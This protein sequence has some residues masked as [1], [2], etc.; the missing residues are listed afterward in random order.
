VIWEGDTPV[1]VFSGLGYY[2]GIA[3]GINDDGWVT[4]RYQSAS[5]TYYHGFMLSIETC[6]DTDGDGYCHDE[7]ECP[8]GSTTS[9]PGCELDDCDETNVNVNPGEAEIPYDGLDNDCGGIDVTDA[10][11]DGYDAEVVGGE[12][13]DD[14]DASINPG[15]SDAFYD[16]IDSNCDGA[17]EWDADGDGYQ[18]EAYN[19]DRTAGGGDCDDS[20]A[21]INP[22]AYDDPTNSID[23]DCSGAA[24]YDADGDGYSM[25]SAGGT[26][27]DDSNSSIYP[28]APDTWYDGI[29]SDCAGDDDYDQDGDGYQHESSP[30]SV[31]DDCDDTDA[32]VVP[33]GTETMDDGVDSDCDGFE[34]C[35]EDADDDGYHDGV[36]IE[37]TDLTCT[38][39]GVAK[40]TD[41]DGDCDDSDAAKPDPD[42][43]PPTGY[44]IIIEGGADYTGASP[45]TIEF[46][47]DDPS[48]T[49]MCFSE[50]YADCTDPSDWY[51][52]TDT[53]YRT[54]AA[55]GGLYTYFVTFRNA[56]DQQET[57]RIS[58]SIYV[59]YAA[60]G[61]GDLTVGQGDGELPVS[62]TEASDSGS[63]VD[64]YI[65]AF[66]RYGGEAPAYFCNLSGASDELYDDNLDSTVTD[67]TVPDLEVG[68]PIYFRLCAVDAMG[69]TSSGIAAWGYAAPEYNAPEGSITIVEDYS[70]SEYVDVTP[71]CTDDSSCEP[72]M[73][74]YNSGEY[75]GLFEDAFTSGT[76]IVHDLNTAGVSST[77]TVYGQF[78][79]E[80]STPSALYSD[81]VVYDST[82]PVNSGLTAGGGDG[83]VTL[84]W[85]DG[86]DDYSGVVGYYVMSSEAAEPG[87]CSAA[88]A[89]AYVEGNEHSYL[90]LDNGTTY[91]FRV[92]A[93]DAAGNVASGATVAQK[94]YLELNPPEVDS[95]TLKNGTNT[96]WTNKTTVTASL[97]ASDDTEVS[98]MCV[99]NTT[100]CTTFID[101]STSFSH[102]LGGS[103][104]TRT[105]YAK[106]NDSSANTSPQVS[107]SIGYDAT[108]PVN[109]TMTA[110][111]D[112][113]GIAVSW[114][115]YSD[116]TSGVD[117]YVV[118]RSAASATG[119]PTSCLRGT[120]V[121]SGSDS[122]TVIT[123]LDSFKKYYIRVCAVDAAGNYSTGKTASATSGSGGGGGF[124]S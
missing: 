22:G 9:T 115:G 32:S 86:T 36:V 100:S 53:E 88:S 11:G 35:Y 104:S 37:S 105:A 101:Y 34:L 79:D 1:D 23:E 97:V 13:C 77:V 74:L 51:A 102:K 14:L 8:D 111:T 43:C 112:S 67:V 44:S 26:D 59:D 4:G 57:E 106:V 107:D 45:I 91:Y 118:T 46:T 68:I 47:V 54:P 93:V 58:D 30:T 6:L 18:L 40:L 98:T 50:V 20:D 80:Y 3:Y 49:E 24:N 16:D 121:Y 19:P 28:G 117:H 55:A 48:N 119:A 85:A 39:S 2:H 69:N 81:T 122:S 12:D 120:I 10:D 31:V 17:D 7:S 83:F 96:A 99:S 95:F 110:T 114:S 66:N 21:S 109:G 71:T 61:D 78:K 27:C 33:F 56:D 38:G 76:P 108:R 72:N 113:S 90:G 29:D 124:G 63:G 123:G 89:D 41:P 103:G 5:G 64:H 70:Q 75:P 15:A 94:A 65:L 42:G 52:F 82:V 62:W 87:S 92:C 60:P 116:A 25:L 73:D 84:S